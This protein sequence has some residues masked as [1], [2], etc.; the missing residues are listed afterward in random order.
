MGEARSLWL[1][2][3]TGFGQTWLQVWVQLLL[4]WET[5]RNLLN[6][7][8]LTVITC[9]IHLV[10]VAQSCL[11]LHEPWTGDHQARLSMG[12]PRQ[13]YWRS[14]PFP[15]LEDLPNPGIE[16]CVSCTVGGFFTI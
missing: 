16:P 4:G 14:L 3:T 10:L 13:E 2:L 9:E 5:W 1:V 7:S 11:T 8:E 12:I 15:S 6:L